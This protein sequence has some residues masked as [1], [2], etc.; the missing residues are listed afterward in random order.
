MPDEVKAKHIGGAV[1]SVLA[2]VSGGSIDVKQGNAPVT[3]LYCPE[4]RSAQPNLDSKFS[5]FGRVV[6][7]MDVAAAI[8]SAG[9]R[10]Q[11][12]RPTE[13]DHQSHNPEKTRRSTR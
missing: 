5:V 13:S 2:A 7:G 10:R 6:E 9:E 1:S 4:C 12:W 3:I 8:S 11:E